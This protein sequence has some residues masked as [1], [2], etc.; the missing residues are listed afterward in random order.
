MIA[1]A[2]KFTQVN[3]EVHIS[4]KNIGENIEIT[5]QDTGVGMTQE[6]INQMFKGNVTTRGTKNEK[7]TGLGLILV[8]DFI[9][10]NNGTIQVESE[11]GKGSTF[12]LT[13][14]IHEGQ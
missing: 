8:K 9:E 5:V 4:A 2:I 1:N 13:L 3:G 10:K 12:R 11:V 14:P 7:G 6:V